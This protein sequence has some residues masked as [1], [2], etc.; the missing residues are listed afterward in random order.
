[1]HELFELPKKTINAQKEERLLKKFKPRNSVAE[2]E[3]EVN[4]E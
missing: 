4:E 3:N 2:L 1:M